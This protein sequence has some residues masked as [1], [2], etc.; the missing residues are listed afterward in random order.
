MSKI[1][2]FYHE[3]ICKMQQE[4]DDIDFF[5][6]MIEEDADVQAFEEA[7]KDIENSDMPSF[8]HSNF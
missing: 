6:S 3:E 2:E 1:K 4:V 7:R 8:F 5:E